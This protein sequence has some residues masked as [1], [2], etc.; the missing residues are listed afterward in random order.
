MKYYLVLPAVAA[1]AAASIISCTKEEKAILDENGRVLVTATVRLPEKTKLSYSETDSSGKDEG[2]K[3]V[4]EEGDCF[5]AVTGDGQS[6]RFDLFEGA[7][8][9]KAKFRAYA[10]DIGALTAWTAV[11]GSGAEQS[12]TD[13]LCKYAG[14]DGTAANLGRNDYIVCTG[15]GTSP[16]FNFSSGTRLSYFLRIKLPAGVRYIEYCTACWWKVNTSAAAIRHEGHFDTVYEADLGAESAAGDW[17]YLAIP[18]TQ[19]G[20]YINEYNKGAILTFM[21][22]ARNKS[23]GRVISSDLSS[24]GGTVGTFDVSGM[25]LFDRPLPSEAISFGA[26]TVE[27]VKYGAV[28]TTRYTDN[29]NNLGD[30]VYRSSVS[31]EWAPYNLGANVSGASAASDLYGRY[32]CWGETAPRTAFAN[33]AE[34]YLYNGSN[35][36]GSMVEFPSTQIG[37]FT[38]HLVSDGSSHGTLKLQRI[39]GTKYDAARV[40]W[41][42]EWRMPTEEEWYLFTGSSTE[43]TSTGWAAGTTYTLDTGFE[44]ADVTESYYGVSVRGR[45]FTKDGQSVF[46]PYAGIYDT[47][48]RWYGARGFYWSDTRIRATPSNANLSNQPLRVEWS[49]ADEIFFGKTTGLGTNADSGVWCGLPV[50]PVR[51]APDME[52]TATAP[53][54]LEDVEGT[55]LLA[56]SNLYGVIKDTDGNPVPGVAVSDGYDVCTTDA[57]GVYQMNADAA[58]RTVSVTVPSAYEIPLDANH[59]PAFWKAVSIPGT[60]AVRKDFTL[61]ARTAV[62]DRFTIIAM[63]DVHVQNSTHLSRFTSA[64]EDVQN[65]V[66]ALGSSIPVGD[67]G[68]AGEVIGIAVGDQLTDNMEMAENVRSAFCGL[69]NASGNTVPVFYVIGNHDYDASYGS[70][71]DCENT[72]ISCFGPTNYSFDIGNAHVIVM[73]DIIRTGSASGSNGTT[74]ITYS[75][76]FTSEQVDWL[77]AD[78]ARVSGAGSKVVVFCCHAPLNTASG[79][80]SGTQNAVMSALKN[81]FYNVHV[82]SGHTHNTK[83][84][85]YGGWAAKSGRSIY[86][87]TFQS[88]SG[89]WWDADICYTNGSPAGYGVLTFGHDD[90][91]A[92]YNKVTKESAGFQMRVYNGSSTYNKNSAWDEM[93]HGGARGYKEYTWD[94]PATG[95]F[96]VRLWDAGSANDAEDY[97]TVNLTYGGSTVPMSRV[98]E[99]IKDAAA[100]SYVFN[101]I[102]GTYGDANGTTDQIWYSGGSFGTPFTITATHIM[103]SGWK[104]TYSSTSYVGTDYKGFA[105]GEHYD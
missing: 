75:E 65:T 33:D 24:K 66:M 60:G 102:Q 58:A 34:H 37:F 104:A 41:G 82:L 64:L 85:L 42:S 96:V 101:K 31:P 13:I 100:A 74:R 55:A 78:I 98:S 105:Y 92:E 49:G 51:N 39:S 7:G 17:C 35:T 89:Y 56:S 45:K 53:A 76:G 28:S 52:A 29:Y 47:G 79:G 57:N 11:L 38:E 73:D 87:H 2:L 16:S 5:Y 97:W 23:N 32:F 80:D 91:I 50:R 88:M 27:M 69:V 94:S 62:P 86:E 90:I 61:T 8:G 14:Q 30:Y 84:N 3:S 36:V 77:R 59:Q 68:L 48:Y 44:T 25:E 103:K 72:F 6:V 46:F 26:G 10:Y 67:G 54:V 18:A 70:D 40:I 1:I 83:N 71:Y 15:S 63:S 19:Y 99:P 95:K 81:N 43:V 93:M 9:N 22:A 4:W 12:G 20:S 21:N